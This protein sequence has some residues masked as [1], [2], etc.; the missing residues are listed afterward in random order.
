MFLVLFLHTF[1]AGFFDGGNQY[2][3]KT[4]GG[5]QYPEKTIGC[6]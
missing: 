2:P 3:E 1:I 6:K 4:R 5:N